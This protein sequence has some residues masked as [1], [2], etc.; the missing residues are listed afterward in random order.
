MEID[1]RR[2]NLTSKVGTRAERVQICSIVIY[3]MAKKYNLINSSS[4]HYVVP[5]SYFD[6]SLVFKFY[7][8][9][10][11]PLYQI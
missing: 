3:F 2:D 7:Y 11:H 1:F 8:L 9:G 5:F 10:C 4:I 6:K